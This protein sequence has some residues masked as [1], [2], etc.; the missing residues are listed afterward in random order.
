M[1][2]TPSTMAA[3]GNPANHFNLLDVV[4]SR[5][6]SLADLA[7]SRGLLVMFICAH[8]PFVKLINEELAAL[9][10]DYKAKGLNIVAICSNNVE[11]HPDDA[12]EKLKAQ[13]ETFGFDFPYL[14]DESQEVA[15]LYTAACTPDFFLY[16]ADR[17]LAYRGQ[18]DGARPGN[19]VP[20]TGGD[21][22]AAIEAVL[23]GQ[24]PSPEQ[25]PSI[26][27]NIKWKRGN[28]PAYAGAASA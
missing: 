2:Q 16:D 18:L 28:E 1:A 26:G 19:G 4:S 5:M 3:L 22:R 10:R 11:T 8:C 15:K 27:C 6:V 13:A 7:G 14:Y 25:Q 21:L 20:V 12:P 9:G 24:A 23:A 17:R